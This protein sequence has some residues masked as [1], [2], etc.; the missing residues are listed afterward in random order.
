MLSRSEN[1]SLI[2]DLI[3]ST[4]SCTLYLFSRSTQTSLTALV[5]V[6]LSSG[7]QGLIG[8]SQYYW[9]KSIFGTI[10]VTICISPIYDTSISVPS[11][12][13]IW[14]IVWLYWVVITGVFILELSDVSRYLILQ[15]IEFSVLF[16]SLNVFVWF[17][18]K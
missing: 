1:I 18:S 17:F 9:L 13:W 11:S 2:K 14:L 3:S 10:G 8:L 7:W 6:I 5:K 12:F 16:R 4:F 15:S